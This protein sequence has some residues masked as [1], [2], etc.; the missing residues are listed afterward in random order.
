MDTAST[1]QNDPLERMLER[2][3]DLDEHLLLL[4]Q[5]AKFDGSDRGIAAL[6]LCQLAFEHSTALRILLATGL[7]TSATSLMRLQFEAVTRALW[8]TYAAGDVQVGKLDAP[9]TMESQQAAKSL[10][11]VTGMIEELGKVS[12]IPAAA[13]AHAMLVQ[14]KQE[15]L[16]ALNSF[17]HG[18]IH[19]LRRCTEG[20]PLPL[21]L[22]MLRN[23]N[24]LLTMTG[25]TLAVLTGDHAIARPMSQI[26]SLFA[27]CLPHLLPH[28]GESGRQ[29]G[30]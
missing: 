5:D 9:L 22:D 14:F 3:N 21:A 15:C 1:V 2:S 10:P 23:S 30:A 6:G 12:D 4:L 17:V 16:H 11:S 19:P 27:D 7:A 25:M 26:Q 13:A 18:G 28:P 20:F 24:G 29:S 8:V